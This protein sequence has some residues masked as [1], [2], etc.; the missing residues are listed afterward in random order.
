VVWAFA[1]S[2][3]GKT[4][5]TPTRRVPAAARGAGTSVAVRTSELP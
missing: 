5:S 2:V 3:R 4:V 1:A